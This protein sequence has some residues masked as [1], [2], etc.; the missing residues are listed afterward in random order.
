MYNM[1]CSIKD[2]RKLIVTISPNRRYFGI[3]SCYISTIWRKI[4]I[5]AQKIIAAQA[6]MVCAMLIIIGR[7]VY[8]L[9]LI[10]GINRS[11]IGDVYI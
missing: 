4:N 1:I 9:K 7:S 11:V 2:T 10:G 5:R 8:R 6:T 3:L